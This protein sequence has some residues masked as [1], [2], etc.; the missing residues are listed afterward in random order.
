M[1]DH[2]HFPKPAY[3]YKYCCLSLLLPENS[4]WVLSTIQ[5]I[6][7]LGQSLLQNWCPNNDGD[8]M[9]VYLK[10]KLAAFIA[11]LIFVNMKIGTTIHQEVRERE[12]RRKGAGES[13]KERKF[14]SIVFYL[15]CFLKFHLQLWKR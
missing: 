11:G 2:L 10:M 7:E 9:D 6:A 3:I 4:T 13:R 8:K 15:N 1:H 5:I 14:L 12:E